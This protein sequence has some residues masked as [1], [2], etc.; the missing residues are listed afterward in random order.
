MPGIG[1]Y[2]E[3]DSAAPV[4]YVLIKGVADE[5]GSLSFKYCNNQSRYAFS[6]A[7]ILNFKINDNYG[8][9]DDPAVAVVEAMQVI[10]S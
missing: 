6:T 8:A 7:N 2:V 9:V 3:R 4:F 1:V 10:G 5:S